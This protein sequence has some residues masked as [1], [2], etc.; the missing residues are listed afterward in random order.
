MAQVKLN[1]APG[2]QWVRQ[3]LGNSL[4]VL[5]FAERGTVKV[6]FRNGKTLQLAIS[7]IMV[8]YELASTG[9]AATYEARDLGETVIRQGHQRAPRHSMYSEDSKKLA[10]KWASPNW[11]LL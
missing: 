7:H 1:V 6:R 8:K 9:T 2:Q 11:E 5:G 10:N 3:D 4:E